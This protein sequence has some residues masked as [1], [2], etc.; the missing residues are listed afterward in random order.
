MQIHPRPRQEAAA[1]AAAMAE[2]QQLAA[3]MA[4]DASQAYMQQG[5]RREGVAG[6]TA[7]E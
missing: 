6:G 5:E 2:A 3:Q 7:K 4:M 1:A